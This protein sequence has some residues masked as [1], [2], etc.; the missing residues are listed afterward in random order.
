M[1]ALEFIFIILFFSCFYY[2]VR[3][4]EVHLMAGS[5]RLKEQKLDYSWWLFR[6][7]KKV[8]TAKEL[9]DKEKVQKAIRAHNAIVVKRKQ[10]KK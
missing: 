9:W 7:K 8:A 1:I 2:I 4:S 5:K 6:N 10:L 3:A